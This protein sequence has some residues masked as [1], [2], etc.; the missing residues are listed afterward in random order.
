MD[1]H[2]SVRE[3]YGNVASTKGATCCAPDCCAR[4]PDDSALKIGYTEEQLAAIPT[5][6][7]LGLG[8]GNPLGVAALEP[9]STVLDLGSGAGVDVFLAAQ[10]VGEK[11]RVIGVDMTPQ[12]LDRARANAGDDYPNVEFRLGEIE[13]LPIGDA[14]VDVVISNCVINLSPD[15][16]QVFRE[17]FRV[18]R[19]G[20]RIQVSDVLALQPLPRALQLSLAAVAACVGGAATVEDT[21][22]M[23]EDAGFEDIQVE[24]RDVA[25]LVDGWLSGAGSYVA[26]ATITATRPE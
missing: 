13:H 18:L 14:E 16:P 19:P 24:T 3:F 7:N 21:V 2:E 22:A 23:L 17:V 11:G 26:P 25:K 1:T 6:A 8:C 9:G 4:T 12:M 10:A 20:G 5:D 15:K